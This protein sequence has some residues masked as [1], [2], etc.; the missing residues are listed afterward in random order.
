VF[1]WQRDARAARRLHDEGAPLAIQSDEKRRILEVLLGVTVRGGMTAEDR[2]LL[3]RA[4][5]TG[6][7]ASQRRAAFNAQIRAEVHLVAGEVAQAV[8][9]VYDADANGLVDVVWL[10][11]CPLLEG[12]RDTSELRSVR[13]S[14]ALRAERVRAVLDAE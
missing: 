6:S 10:E 3:A 7:D 12:I 13:R 5:P 11:H 9:I 8:E 14:T 4:F 2:D 1:L